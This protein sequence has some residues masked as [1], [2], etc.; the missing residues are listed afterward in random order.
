[1]IADCIVKSIVTFLEIYRSK[2]YLTKIYT[3][4]FFNKLL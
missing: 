2:A 3:N 4:S 1:L